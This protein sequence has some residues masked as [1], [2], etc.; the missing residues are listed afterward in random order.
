MG[1]TQQITAD[2]V[3]G[4]SGAPVRLYGFTLRSG[5]G[6]AGLAIFYNGT[7]ATGTE[8]YRTS[9][10]QDG[11]LR[12][13]FGMS[14]KFFPGGLYIDIDADVLYVDCDYLQVTV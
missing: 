7:D 4:K 5:G 2:G 1:G 10:Q 6:G 14:G 13:D 9:G 8:K 11:V 3:V 12:V